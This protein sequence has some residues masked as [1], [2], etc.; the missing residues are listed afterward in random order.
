M[1]FSPLLKSRS[2]PAQNLDSDFPRLAVQFVAVLL[3]DAPLGFL[4]R[5]PHDVI[6]LDVLQRSDWRPKGM[7]FNVDHAALTLF[8]WV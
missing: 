4:K 7:L 6:A 3:Y 5:A 8:S 1:S 2:H